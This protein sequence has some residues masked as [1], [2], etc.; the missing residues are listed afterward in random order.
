M[1]EVTCY[2]DKTPI[3]IFLAH[4]TAIDCQPNNNTRRIWLIDNTCY[5]VTETYDEIIDKIKSK[6]MLTS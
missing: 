6:N 5:S 2:K 3:T 4:V 1:I